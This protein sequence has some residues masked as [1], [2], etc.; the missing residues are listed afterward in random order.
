M[1]QLV[2]RFTY[3]FRGSRNNVLILYLCANLYNII[4]KANTG[5]K[6]AETRVTDRKGRCQISLTTND[7]YILFLH[8]WK[9]ESAKLSADGIRCLLLGKAKERGFDRRVGATRLAKIISE[10]AG[11]VS[12]AGRRRRRECSRDIHNESID[13]SNM[14]WAI[15]EEHQVTRMGDG[16]NKTGQDSHS[17]FSTLYPSMHCWF[18]L[19]HFINHDREDTFYWTQENV[20]LSYHIHLSIEQRCG[21]GYFS[22]SDSATYIQ[23]SRFPW[24]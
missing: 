13:R 2:I 11:H 22:A 12:R 8:N 24:A 9:G 6:I 7:P 18:S 5:H 16:N 10:T 4:R 19:I 3:I 15:N 1:P 14:I 17:I 23:V 21:S 20:H